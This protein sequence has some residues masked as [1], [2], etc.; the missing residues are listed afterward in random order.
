MYAPF[1]GGHSMLV[2]NLT[3]ALRAATG[4]VLMILGLAAMSAAILGAR[5]LI[6][7][8]NHGDRE[9]VLR[10]IDKLTP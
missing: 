10:L 4:A 3:T 6:F 1:I 5:Y 9:M 7:E 2:R 8:Y